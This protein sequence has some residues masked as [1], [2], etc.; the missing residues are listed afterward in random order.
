MPLQDLFVGEMQQLLVEIQKVMPDV[1]NW[2]PEPMPGGEHHDARAYVGT[3][4]GW[5]FVVIDFDITEQG[6]PPGSRGYDGGAT[7]MGKAIVMH[8][9][10]SLAEM[11][12]KLAVLK[13]GR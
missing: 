8:L 3:G 9:T 13:T 12:F 10:Q 11:G 5:R 2:L 1:N 7:H 6:F 4:G